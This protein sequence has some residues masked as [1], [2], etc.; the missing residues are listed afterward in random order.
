MGRKVDVSDLV[1]AAEIAD[2]LGLSH[3]Q[4]VHNLKRRNPDTFP[5]PVAKLRQAMVWAWPDVE[6]WARA[7]GRLAA[8]G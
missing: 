4:S 5:E 7:T 3:A 6:A 2:R 1:G 8:E